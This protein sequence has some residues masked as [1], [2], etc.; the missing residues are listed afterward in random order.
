MGGEKK[1]GAIGKKRKKERGYWNLLRA[2][3]LFF[4]E[5]KKSQ[6]SFII[7]L[8]KVKYVRLGKNKEK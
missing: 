3:S 1:R 2:H 6:Q 4:A 8:T 5:A 7:I